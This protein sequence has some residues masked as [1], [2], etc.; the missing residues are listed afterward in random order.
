MYDNGGLLVLINYSV[1]NSCRSIGCE[2][3]TVC[4][5]KPVPC[6]R[7][8]ESASICSARQRQGLT[9]ADFQEDLRAQEATVLDF[10]SEKCTAK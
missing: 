2:Y 5:N 1:Q 6:D 7:Y 4:V 9:G 8:V 3:V 10:I